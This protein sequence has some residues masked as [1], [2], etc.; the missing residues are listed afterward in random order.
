MKEISN[1][2]AGIVLTAILLSACSQKQKSSVKEM[3]KDS[4]QQ[5]EVL[6]EMAENHELGQ[7][8]IEKMMENDHATGMMVDELVK[9]AAND[10]I[11]A[12]KI[13][14]MITK[15][16]ELMLLTTHHF[17]PVIAS[18]SLLSDTFCDDTL[19]QEDLAKAMHNKM[20]Y[21]KSLER[22]H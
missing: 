7:K 13:S 4:S 12:G 6:T 18:D 20:E 21:R 1:K 19:E 16:P 9:A 17:I 11:L 10:T 15:Y 22:N 8:Y 2:V 5:E 3:L 14:E